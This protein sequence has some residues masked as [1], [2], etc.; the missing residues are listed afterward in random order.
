M[1]KSQIFGGLLFP[2]YI[3][4][5]F[6][7]TF[8]AL[9]AQDTNPRDMIW[10]AGA[11]PLS[12]S[13]LSTRSAIENP[14]HAYEYDHV[15][16]STSY[17]PELGVIEAKDLLLQTIESQSDDDILS[18]SHDYGGI[19]SRYAELETDKISS[20]IFVGVP[21]N[22]SRFLRE[23]LRSSG[24][25]SPDIILDRALTIVG[26][27]DCEDCGVISL[28]RDWI[29]DIR[30]GSEYLRDVEYESVIISD[31]NNTPPSVPYVNIMGD[32]DPKTT[33]NF[34]GILDSRG[35]LS[36]TPTNNLKNCFIELRNQARK[37]LEVQ[38]QV[39][40]MNNWAGAIRQITS[41]IS[42]VLTGLS[43]GEGEGGGGF[44]PDI[45]GAVGD[46][47][48]NFFKGRIERIERAN[49]IQKETARILRC[50]LAVQM[51][52]V[53]MNSFLGTNGGDW[54]EEEVEVPS[55]DEYRNCID[56]CGVDMA[57]GDWRSPLSCDE[58]CSRFIDPNNT[59]TITVIV[60]EFEGHDWVYSLF[61]QSLETDQR[62]Q[63]IVINADHFQENLPGYIINP[64]LTDIFD[65][66]YGAAFEVPKK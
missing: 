63:E 37:D 39:H 14:P 5:S 66:S 15:L 23:A 19:V 32:V 43:G 38:R 45:I 62:V 6:F 9:N 36:G 42:G 4:L 30:G 17:D 10:V 2:L 52:A 18:I 49:E 25:N 44:N 7:L 13:W 54:I 1:N 34:L 53:E 33:T 12:N 22:G 56:E 47:V 24:Q 64:V 41:A 11:G 50:D 29:L 3:F 27:N 16:N 46:I 35:S 60:Y 40:V 65:G 20:M 51:V 55:L 28:L 21:H 59:T 48:N 58:Y 26:E 61:E 8:P 31:I 57:W